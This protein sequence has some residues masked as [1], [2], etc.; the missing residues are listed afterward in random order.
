MWGGRTRG[1]CV[2]W[3]YE[4]GGGVVFLGADGDDERGVHTKE[5]KQGVERRDERV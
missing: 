3:G 1:V 5:V 4:V 2:S